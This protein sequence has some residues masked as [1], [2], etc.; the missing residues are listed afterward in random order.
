MRRYASV[1]ILILVGSCSIFGG[2]PMVSDIDDACTIIAERP[3]WY[4]A[5][6]NT[7][8]KWGLPPEVLFS[9]IWRESNF[10]PEAK[11]PRTYFLGFIPTGRVSTA[12][13]YPQAIDGTWDWYRR[14]TGNRYAS[15]ESFRDAADFIGWYSRTT[16]RRNGI[17]QADAYHQYLAYHEGHTG[18]RRG[19]WKK[20]DWLLRAASAVRRQSQIYRSQLSRCT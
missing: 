17:A 7:E 15:R 9:I 10:R 3:D 14:E 1:V 19:N 8:S 16:L 2:G 13:G 4:R 5:A 12:Y 11:T 20:K 6:R 18:Y